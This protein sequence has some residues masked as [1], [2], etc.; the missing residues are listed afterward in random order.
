MQGHLQLAYCFFSW[1][2][3]WSIIQVGVK[4]FFGVKISDV[5]FQ[6]FS[7][8]LME[9]LGPP[10]LR[11]QRRRRIFGRI[12]LTPINFVKDFIWIF[13]PFWCVKE[14][15]ND[16]KSQFIIKCKYKLVILRDLFVVNIFGVNFLWCQMPLESR[17]LEAKIFGSRLPALIMRVEHRIY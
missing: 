10:G 7:E 14:W 13:T 12:W 3:R 11:A 16:L 9:P 17:F 4:L 2:H 6:I 1:L 5:I 15:K 8:A